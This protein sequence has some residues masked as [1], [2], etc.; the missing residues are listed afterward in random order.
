MRAWA[1]INSGPWLVAAFV[2]L[3]IVAADVAKAPLDTQGDQRAVL[4]R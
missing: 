4:M 3:I 2:L 1:R